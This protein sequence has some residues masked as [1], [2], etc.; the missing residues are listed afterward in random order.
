MATT[1]REKMQSGDWYCCLDPE[2]D[3]LRHAAR[4][5]VHQHNI[6]APDQNTPFS[7]PLA[8][9][10]AAHGSQCFIEAPFHCAYGINI[11]LGDNV[12]LNAGCTILDSAPVTIGDRCMFGPNVQIYCAQHHKDAALRS[13]GQEIVLPVTIGHDVW[14]GGGALIMPG[15]TICDRAIIGAGSV[16]LRDVAA[17]TTVVGSPARALAS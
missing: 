3:V 8:K 2:L 14:I 16:V 12:Y 13:Q 17:A 1:E 5:A 7:P 4:G 11:S 10:F 15:V 6:A 9:L